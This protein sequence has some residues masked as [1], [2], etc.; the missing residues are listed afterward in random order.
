MNSNTTNIKDNSKDMEKGK[1]DLLD[2]FNIWS[3]GLSRHSVQA[4]YAIIAAN[5]ATHVKPNNPI[6]ADTSACWSIGICIAF[7][8]ANIMITGVLNQLHKDRWKEAEDNTESWIR[9]FN[10]RNDSKSQWPYTKKID[11]Y[12]VVLLYLRTFAPLIAGAIFIHSLIK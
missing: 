2:A 12:G 6:L 11:N 8:M 4:T 1:K 9:D 5:W 10:N 7:I 3:E